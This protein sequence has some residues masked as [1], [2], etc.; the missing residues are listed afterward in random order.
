M[1]DLSSILKQGTAPQPYSGVVHN[2]AATDRTLAPY[3]RIVRSTTHASI[4]S[5]I[6]LC[7][8]AEAGAGAIVAVVMVVDNNADTIVAGAVGG[9][10]TLTAVNDYLVVMSTGSEWLILGEVST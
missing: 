2:P 8:P 10:V 7:N 6:T 4:D 3:E 1:N 9:N 5:T